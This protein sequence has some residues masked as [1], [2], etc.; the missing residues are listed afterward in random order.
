VK[1]YKGYRLYVNL[2]PSKVR[3]ILKGHGLGVKKVQSAGRNQAVVIHTATGDNL[4]K[5]KQLFAGVVTSESEAELGHPLENLR[6]L[7]PQSIGWLNEINLHTR[8]DLEAIG[9]VAAYRLIKERQPAASLN[10]L[11]AMAGALADTDWRD[12]PESTRQRLQAEA[13]GRSSR[14]A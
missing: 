7:G 1:D 4:R 9:P 5:L 10:L 14:G 13:E 8:A 11:W 2:G 3:R 12:L 6:N